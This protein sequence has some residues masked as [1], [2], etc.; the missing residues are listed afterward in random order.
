MPIT[1]A[2]FVLGALAIAGLP[3]LNGFLSKLTVYLALAKAGM[4][5]ALV[6]A[7]AAGLLTMIVL[8]RAAR[9]VFWG[10]APA[11][12]VAVREV[13]ATMW[14]PMVILAV[15]CVVLG[16]FPRLPFPLLDRAAVVL[17]TLGR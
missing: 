16:V 13:P 3:P 17:A 6:I 5:W 2:C 11:T 8:L 12:T 4:W 14:V 10:R 9:T 7:V 15:A 1:S